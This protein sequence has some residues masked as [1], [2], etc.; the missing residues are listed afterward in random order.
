[1][2]KRIQRVGIEYE[3]E[4]LPME[5]EEYCD[6]IGAPPAWDIVPDGT[7]RNGGAEFVSRVL[8]LDEA[9]DTVANLLDHLGAEHDNSHRCSMHIHISIDDLVRWQRLALYMMLVAEE[10]FFFQYNPERKKNH[11]CTPLLYTPAFYQGLS[12][13]CQAPDW[14]NGSP[15]KRSRTLRMSPVYGTNCKY[16]SVNVTPALEGEGI[17][18]LE[19]RHFAPLMQMS[20]VNTILTKIRQLTDLAH[21]CPATRSEDMYTFLKAHVQDFSS[22]P[23]MDWVISAVSQLQEELQSNGYRDMWDDSEDRERSNIIL[24]ALSAGRASNPFGTTRPS[25]SDWVDN[26][27]LGE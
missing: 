5:Y 18:T 20:Q 14:S 24:D 21:E 7:L 2:S 15:V 6:E 22:I 13:M 23:A 27:D 4:G 3:I 26:L 11:Y 1:M 19:L 8:T 10:D 16:T 17:G 9:P 12:L 25:S